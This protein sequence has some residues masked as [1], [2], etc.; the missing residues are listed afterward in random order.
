MDMKL[1]PSAEIY[2]P[3]GEVES[4][5]VRSIWRLCEWNAAQRLETILPKGTVEI[6]F[7]LS[8]EVVY[9]NA[10]M[11]NRQTLPMCFINGINF[12]P[13]KLIKAGQQEFLGLQLNTIGI[14]AL[15]GIAVSEFNNNIYEGSQV[16]KSLRVLSNKLFSQKTFQ[17]QVETIMEWISCRISI[18]NCRHAIPQIHQM[19]Y[20]RNLAGHSVKQFSEETRLSDRHLRRLSSDWLGMNTEAFLLYNKYLSALNLLH[21]SEMALTEIGY[22]AG[23]YD[24]AHF[25]RAFKSFTGLTPKEYRKSKSAFLGHLF[26]EE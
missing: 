22:E 9:C 26:L 24:Q 4:R 10:A 11:D 21:H 20:S 7:N 12:Q 3:S 19:Y 25:I 18:S 2:F 6:I 15:F 16:C 17:A 13:F 5:F 8:D 23:Y 14:K 1:N